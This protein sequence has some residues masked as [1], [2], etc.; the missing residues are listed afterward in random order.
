MTVI[1]KART[2]PPRT[3]RTRVM[4]KNHHK[5]MATI[6]QTMDRRSR[7]NPILKKPMILSQQMTLSR[8]MTRQVEKRRQTKARHP[9][10]IQ[11]TKNLPAGTRTKKKM[12]TAVP[13]HL[14]I[15]REKLA[16]KRIVKDRIRH[17]HRAT[18]FLEMAPLQILNHQMKWILNT[19]KKPRT[20]FWIT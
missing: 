9:P 18:R 12:G 4:D 13:T 6:L 14:R 3:N 15:R 17:Q 2:L 11:M 20:S 7:G 16:I 8:Q 1:R 19:P 5:A 10:Q